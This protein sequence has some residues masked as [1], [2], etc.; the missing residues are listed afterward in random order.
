MVYTDAQL[1]SFLRKC[2][3]ANREKEKA[4]SGTSEHFER[5]IKQQ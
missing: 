5:V 4:T 3:A 1:S 2:R